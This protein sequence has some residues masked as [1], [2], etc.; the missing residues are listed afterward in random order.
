MRAIILSAGL[1]ERLRPL[2]LKRAKPA[3]EFLNIPML[4]FPYYWL[5]SVDVSH[6]VFNTHYLPETVKHAAMHVVSP[7]CGL[8]LS[9]EPEILGSGGGI[10]QAYVHLQWDKTF[11]VANADAL[12]VFEE[13]DTIEQM[14]HFHLKKDA[15]ATLL[16]CELDGVGQKYGGVWLDNSGEVSNFGKTPNKDYLRGLH[17]ASIMFLSHRIWE[18][19]PHGPS[20]ILFDVLQPAIAQGE[21]VY[22]FIVDKMRW[23]E[24]G[25]TADYLAAT[26]ACL[27]MLARKDPGLL[28]ILERFT[29]EFER[30]SKL[31]DLQLIASEAS[32]SDNVNL[33]GFGVIGA[34]IPPRCNLENVVILPGAHL[35]AGAFLQNT[36]LI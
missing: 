32:L 36:V 22:G 29:P 2:T 13:L 15:L 7:T 9:F 25:N 8:H 21:K 19:L 12:V 10:G 30:Q 33:Q 1:G 3:I 27:E 31:K 26:K 35:Q 28:A 5:D 17:F 18:Y 6:V 11:A 4:A 20:N 34:D 14:L 23:F 16:V 24:T